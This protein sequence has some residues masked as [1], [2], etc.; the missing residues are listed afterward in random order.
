MRRLIA[1]ACA[2]LLAACAQQPTAPF[3]SPPPPPP[4]TSCKA[5][6]AQYAI[7]RAQTA[8]LVEEIR[9][10]SGAHIARIL[11]PNQP[12]TLEFLAER[13]NVVVDAD[14]KITAVRCG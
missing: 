5:D 14:N 1:P 12:V 7:G 9:Q 6:P 2:L 11:R 4:G 13:V 10:R 8:P 3:A